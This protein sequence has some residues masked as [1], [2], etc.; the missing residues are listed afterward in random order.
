MRQVIAMSFTEMESGASLVRMLPRA[1]LAVML[2]AGPTAWSQDASQSAQEQEGGTD[3]ADLAPAGAANSGDQI[4]EEELVGLPLNGRSYS[5]LATLQA[6][7]TDSESSS[8]SRGGGSGSLNVVGGRSTS[9]S[10]L[11][12]GTNIMD[13]ANQVPRSAAGVQLGSDAVLQVR[14]QSAF[15]G[16]EYGRGSG[17]VLNSITRSGT[18]RLHGSVFEF[19][20][21]SSL[22]ARNFF[23]PEAEPPP[24]KRNQF[25][26]TLTGP[27]WR[28]RTFFMG[29]YEGLR[30]RLTDTN[31]D[32]FPN[33]LTR[34]GI[35]TDR[36]GNVLQTVDVHPRVAPY[37]DEALLPLP[38]STP[39]GNGI[40]LNA[41]SQFLP[42]NE[43][44][45]TVRVD[46]QLSERDSMFL[47]YTFDDA[48]S[49]ASE[50]TYLWSQQ[51]ESRQQYLTLVGSHIF[52]PAVVGSVRLSYTRPVK[53]TD[54]LSL[55]EVPREL[56]FVPSAPQSG[57][58]NVPSMS[59]FGPNNGLPNGSTMNTFQYA[60]DLFSRKGAHGLRMGF[61]IHRYRL[62]SFSSF[63]QG[64]T[65][66]FNSLASF[67]QAGPEGTS[68]TVGLPGSDNSRAFR[69][70]LVGMYF[71][72]EYQLRPNLQLTL[73]VRYEP[74]TKLI[75]LADKN[76]SLSDPLHDTTVEVGDLYRDN[77]TLR[78]VAPRVGFRW[79]PD[80][81]SGTVLSGGFGVFY[82]QILPWTANSRKATYPSY[83]LII[84]PNFDS[85]TTFP[86]AVAG[87]AEPGVNFPRLTIMDFNNTKTP[88]VYRYNLAVQQP[89]GGDVDV[90][91]SYVGARGNHLLRRY[92]LN[93]FPAP[94]RLPDGTLF[95]P[96]DCNQRIALGLTPSPNCRPGAGPVNPAFGSV[97]IMNTDGQSFF[98]TFQLSASRRFS[99]GYSIQGSYT[100]S[101]SVDDDSSGQQGNAFQFGNERGL[102]RALSDYDIRHRVVVNYFWTPPFGPGQR[103]MNSGLLSSIF[104]NWR[105]GGIFRYRS[106]VPTTLSVNIRTPGYLF[107]AT[108]P[109][110]LPGFSNN[111]VEGATAGCE[112]VDGGKELS[113][114]QLH[115]DPCAFGRPEPGT[116]GT[117]GRNT[118]IAPRV[119][120]AD[121][122]IQKDFGL[123]GERR[124]Q[125]RMEIFNVLNHPNFGANQGNTAQVFSGTSQRRGSA[126][127]RMA[128]TAT[129]ARQ[130]QFALRLSF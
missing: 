66:S 36:D 20:R 113:T 15:Y 38:N 48:S 13:S 74:A 44:F 50:I 104:G 8:A 31:I 81:R 96:D 78:N 88:V 75:D 80:V 105:L 57:Q 53:A 89:V 92:E 69:Q 97:D 102:E 19:L 60:G 37:L 119:A 94:V 128:R 18:P 109:N 35:I 77:P 122:S 42:T 112:G 12:D 118:V 59:P 21:N 64:A 1:L 87:A 110:L 11:L 34:Q 28:D 117:L 73:G 90:Q 120:N 33:A 98:N 65:W 61:D 129:T 32:F 100:F 63:H 9:N 45:F 121:L 7:V 17:G 123:G 26:F 30:D 68:L 76:I 93:Q 23:D 6:G 111:P 67:L 14:V 108:R 103:W 2:L 56:F 114:A 52:S 62:E 72:D 126:T 47:R 3:A 70:T 16:A 115:F 27:V 116:L 4:S 54:T 79:S 46:H 91:L 25:G 130:L 43:N 39:L 41:A 22:D 125:F 5:Q 106:G 58:Y 85:S 71:Q 86:D 83:Q 51:V 49:R 107:S 55:L 24:F 124:M 99:Q 95:F 40:G 101:K 10:F 84:N 29:S 82:D 127:G